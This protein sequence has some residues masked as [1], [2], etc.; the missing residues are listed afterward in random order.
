MRGAA[1]QLWER[2][3]MPTIDDFFGATNESPHPRLR[4]WKRRLATK[5]GAA[6]VEVFRTNGEFGQGK[7]EM[8]VQFK[9]GESQTHL[10]TIPWDDDLNAG[11]ILLKVR[12]VSPE[13]EAERFALG[14]RAAMRRIEREFGDGYFNAVLVD[15]IKE[16][17]LDRYP[18]IAEV[19]RYAQAN[20]PP[21]ESGAF[22]RYTICRELIAGARSGCA[23]ELTH[24]LGYTQE[25]A[26][27]I[28]VSA[29]ARSLFGRA[30]L[31]Q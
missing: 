13:Q 16:S 23:K 22:A 19:M 25:E 30:V 24:D 27:G 8:H 7:P 10:D 29:L 21:R 18:E 12:S 6:S 17:R 11:L 14:L 26:K 1:G 3:R 28:L 4:D 20:A 15:L 2:E 31:G 5:N 9:E